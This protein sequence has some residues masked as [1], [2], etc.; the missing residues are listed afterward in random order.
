MTLMVKVKDL[1]KGQRMFKELRIEVPPRLW[2]L[3]YLN[4]L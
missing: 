3:E 2:A 1:E 4:Y